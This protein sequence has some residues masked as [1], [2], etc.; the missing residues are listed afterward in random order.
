METYEI[1]VRNRKDVPATVHVYERFYAEWSFRSTSHKFDKLDSHT[2]DFV[3]NLKA[4]EVI[5][6]VYTVETRWG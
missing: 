2:V 5:K 3:I 4:G 1:E 6:I